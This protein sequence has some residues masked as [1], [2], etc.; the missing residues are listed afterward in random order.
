M[1]HHVLKNF[2]KDW[3]KSI[4]PPN[5]DVRTQVENLF[6]NAGIRVLVFPSA[7]CHETR[8]DNLLSADMANSV[9]LEHINPISEMSDTAP[10]H[11]V[12]IRDVYG[13]E[14]QFGSDIFPQVIASVPDTSGHMR[15]VHISVLADALK[16]YRFRAQPQPSGTT[17]PANMMPEQFYYL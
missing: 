4:K 7:T 9:D 5:T 8:A 6:F 10:R 17:I 12:V 2:W 11:I 1:V 15:D 16:D 13:F 3:L 14:R